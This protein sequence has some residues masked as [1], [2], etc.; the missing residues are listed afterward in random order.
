MIFYY[1]LSEMEDRGGGTAHSFEVNHR[2]SQSHE[3][4]F[5]FVLYVFSNNSYYLIYLSDCI[6]YG[7]IFME[8]FIIITKYCSLLKA[9]D[10]I[11]RG[12]RNLFTLFESLYIPALNFLCYDIVYLVGFTASICSFSQSTLSLL[13]LLSANTTTLLLTAFSRLFRYMLTVQNPECNPVELK[14]FH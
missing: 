4:I 13:L 11:C 5:G 9:H 12:L 6:I 8:P 2:L 10:F 14:V 7:Y 3:K 1:V